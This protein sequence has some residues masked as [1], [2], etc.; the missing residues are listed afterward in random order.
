M[1][2]ELIKNFNLDENQLIDAISKIFG[3]KIEKYETKNDNEILKSL[4]M[5]WDRIGDKILTISSENYPNLKRAIVSV[6]RGNEI[7]VT[8]VNITTYKIKGKTPRDFL[9]QVTQGYRNIVQHEMKRENIKEEIKQKEIK[10][11][12]LT[13]ETIIKDFGL[14][15]TIFYK[16]SDDEMTF[17]FSKSKIQIPLKY[18]DEVVKVIK[19]EVLIVES[20]FVSD[21]DF[22]TTRD[23]F[24]VSPFVY[25]LSNTEF[26]L[27][28]LR[29]ILNAEKELNEKFKPTVE[30]IVTPQVEEIYFRMGSTN[31][32]PLELYSH[33]AGKE[34]QK[35]RHIIDDFIFNL[36]QYI[37]EGAIEKISLKRSD[38]EGSNY[39]VTD[40]R[41]ELIVKDIP[42]LKDFKVSSIQSLKIFLQHY[43]A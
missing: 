29:L 42:Q 12:D 10:F 25:D 23:I 16:P 34:N 2:E 43:F 6:T 9:K 36:Y 18:Y 13:E 1:L 22:E 35:V 32:P 8:M 39:H 26:S 37:I 21:D 41:F 31:L 40:K 5:L 11:E 24:M 19:K 7:H 33:M 3:V 28:V 38:F 14:S 17:T 15:N 20:T 30:K 4:N 27:K